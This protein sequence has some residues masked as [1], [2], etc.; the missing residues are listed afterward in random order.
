M[1][2]LLA[3][4]DGTAFRGRAFG[5]AGERTGEVVFNTSMVGYQEVLTDPSYKGQIVAMTYPEIGNY[6]IN[7]ED[8]ES[9]RPQVEG[10]AIREL[11]ETASNWRSNKTLDLYLKEHRIIGISELDTRALTRHIRSSGAMRGAL[12]TTTLQP[13]ALAA[14]ARAAP[15]MSDQDLVREVTIPL[16]EPWSGTDRPWAGPKS[17]VA[18]ATQTPHI[19]A[20]DFGMKRNI[21]R[22]LA[23][24]GCRITIVPATLS[25]QDTLALMPDGVF[26][27][28]GP[29]DPATATYAVESA[30]GLWGRVPIFGICLGH[31][32]LGI[33]AGGR[34][35]KL[36]FGHHGAN[37]PVLD[38][39]TG[40]VE[41]TSQNHNYAVDPDSLGPG[42][43]VTHI[44][45]NDQTVEGF[46]HRDDPVFSVQFHPES[47]PG[48][49]DSLHLFD[50]FL[51]TIRRFR[52]PETR[53]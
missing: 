46:R 7:D 22:C 3:L 23:E 16:P 45:L 19:V 5:A 34:T 24:A 9:A 33:A 35:F 11:S 12:S 44:N 39:A 37:Q 36:K 10:F 1:E 14:V 48:P 20:F 27:S 42:V 18:G 17:G 52:S 26:L 4:E 41:I 8:I 25:A 40:A 15:Q 53:G 28:N 13:D 43:E 47:S 2:A 50:R 6:G 30:R 51:E 31:Q 49:H 21:L 29:G 32:I 38:R